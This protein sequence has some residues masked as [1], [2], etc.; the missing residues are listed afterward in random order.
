MWEVEYTDEFEEWWQE[1]TNAQQEARQLG[2]TTSMAEPTLGDVMARLDKNDAALRDV[3]DRL[4]GID[5]RLDGIDQRL[6]GVETHVESLY[7]RVSSLERTVN[8]KFAA[9]GAGFGMM[10]EQLVDDRS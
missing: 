8:R 2:E 10:R 3:M 4:V 5:S 9:M 6:D 1:F 7:T